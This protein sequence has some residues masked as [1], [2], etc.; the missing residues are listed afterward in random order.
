MT[1]APMHTTASITPAAV[2]VLHLRLSIGLLLSSCTGGTVEP[3]CRKSVSP[4]IRHDSKQ[5][6]A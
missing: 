6:G 3:L 1:A 2:A 4:A 5:V